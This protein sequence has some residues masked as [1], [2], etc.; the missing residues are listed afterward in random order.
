MSK[1]SNSTVTDTD[2]SARAKGNV[3]TASDVCWYFSHRSSHVLFVRLAHRQLYVLI[4]DVMKEICQAEPSLDTLHSS[5]CSNRI[6]CR[7]AQ[8]ESKPQRAAG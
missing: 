2:S 6:R 5:V 3:Y 7:V 4:Y 8:A 1:S